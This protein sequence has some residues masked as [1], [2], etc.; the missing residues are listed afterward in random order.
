M[1]LLFTEEKITKEDKYQNYE[2]SIQKTSFSR[3]VFL[4]YSPDS[5]YATPFPQYNHHE[6][7]MLI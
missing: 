5:V 1:E 2:P 6:E 3:N 4:D 7:S